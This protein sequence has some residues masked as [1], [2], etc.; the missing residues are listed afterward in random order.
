MRALL[1]DD[2]RLARKRLRDLLAEHPEIEIAGEAASVAE[3]EEFLS[4]QGADIV[5]LDVQMPRQD[6]FQLLPKLP[7]PPP[8]IIFV[9]AH[10]RYAVRAF[11]VNALDYLLKPV[12][13]K[14]LQASIGRLGTPP[15]QT[16]PGFKA[17]DR[18]LLNDGQ[19][20]RFTTVSRLAAIEADRNYTRVHLVEDRPVFVL[21]GIGDWADALPQPPFLRA[22][23]SLIVNVERIREVRTRS[24]DEAAVVL[25]GVEQEFA[26]GRAASVR[27]KAALRQS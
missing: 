5:F 27:V 1:V 11:E 16:W 3:A 22:D 18:I 9:T 24:R 13:P 17:E 14:R 15:D 20:I 19:R 21:R 23:R 12:D 25:E 26:V 10:D 8:R 7:S 2:E 4:H 6:G